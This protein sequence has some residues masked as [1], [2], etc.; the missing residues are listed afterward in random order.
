MPFPSSSVS[1][2]FVCDFVRSWCGPSALAVLYALDRY[3]VGLGRFTACI[4]SR[5]VALTILR[6]ILYMLLSSVLTLSCVSFSRRA[7]V[8]TMAA[9]ASTSSVA[10]EPPPIRWGIVGLG[11]V[12]AVK[13]GPP[14]WKCNGAQLVAVMRRTPGAATQWVEENVPPSSGSCQGYDDLDKFLA[15]PGLDAVYVATPPGSH[16]AIASKVA[17]AGKACYVEKPCGRC[18]HETAAMQKLFDAKGLPLFTAYISRAYPRTEAVLTLLASGAVGDRV[19]RVT[20]HLR[21][22]GG[23]RGMETE[24]AALPWRLDAAQSGG[25][26]IMDVGCH[27]IDRLDYLLGPLEDVS[28]IAENRHSPRQSVEDFVT[29]SARIGAAGDDA[30]ASAVRGAGAEVQMTWDFAPSDASVTA[31]D[32]LV[33]HGPIG[34]VEMAAMSPSAPVSVY[35]ASSGALVK[36]LTFEQPEHTAQALIQAATDELRGLVNGEGVSVACPSRGDNALR[37]SAVLDQALSSFY[38]GRDDRFWERPD[39]WP[40]NPQGGATQ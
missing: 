3:C 39:T 38:G 11:D 15:H 12:T 6:H 18:R 25:G 29:L 14:F 36:Q 28:G 19:T 13:A 20:Y 8:A 35:E 34:R 27:V 9:A 21:G 33:I 7:V 22:S 10:A 1:P 16:L 32:L 30:R 40:G 26:L 31:V 24:A 37:T 2:R 5:A 4:A 23:A 17:A